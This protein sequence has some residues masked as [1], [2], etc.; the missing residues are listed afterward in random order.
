M[1]QSNSL[2]KS[3]RESAGLRLSVLFGSF[4]VLLLLSSIIAGVVDQLPIGT[5]RDHALTVSAIQCLLAF[6]LPA[7]FVAKFSS[8]NWKGWLEL[9][10]MPKLSAVL[11]LIVVYMVSMPAMEWLIEWN[12][13]LH[14]P[15]SMKAIE[16]VM[17]QWEQ[18]AENATNILLSSN[19]IGSMIVGILII[20]V[21]TGF[22]EELFFR[23]GFQGILLRT[24]MNRNMAV[25]LSAFLF[26]MMHFQFFGFLPRLLMGAFFGYLL[27]WSRSIWLPV[28]AHVLNNS[29]VVV[30]SAL[31][32]NASQG[33]WDNGNNSLFIGNPWGI[34]G[35]IVLTT[36]FLWLCR[37]MFKSSKTSRP[38]QKNRRQAAI[39]K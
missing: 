36:L 35:S 22:S 20:G 15:Q 37:D 17:R 25:W 3:V 28:L 26:S 4:F 21:L 16:E 24:S 32:G 1:S 30:T 10:R 31:T 18:N 29:A 14:L 34:I 38:W 39:G 12:A 27:L 13:N 11:G 23:G 9:T 7:F 8:N 2:L 19:G 33:L 6:C 5:A